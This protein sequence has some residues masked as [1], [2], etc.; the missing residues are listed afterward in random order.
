MTILLLVG[1]GYV[2]YVKFCPGYKY[3]VK[4]WPDVQLNVLKLG[5]LVE[6]VGI[7]LCEVNSLY[8]NLLQKARPPQLRVSHTRGLL[9]EY[10]T[11]TL[12]SHT[13]E[14]APGQADG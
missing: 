14:A 8:N 4:F 6:E 5:F 10:C 7:R 3:Y 13:G 9:A 12:T 11:N 1:P 2:Y